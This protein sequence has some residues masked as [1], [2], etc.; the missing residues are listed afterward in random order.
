MQAKAAANEARQR[1]DAM[2]EYR[3]LCGTVPLAGLF[4]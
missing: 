2:V 4:R 3:P 1:I